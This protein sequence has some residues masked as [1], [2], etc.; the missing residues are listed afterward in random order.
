MH[1]FLVSQDEARNTKILDDMYVV[2]P[3]FS[4]SRGMLNKY[5]KYERVPD[6][7]TYTSDKNKIW[8]TKEQLKKAL[9]WL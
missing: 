3:Q 2:L 9:N 8:L 6:G 5:E 7:F 4:E 1:E